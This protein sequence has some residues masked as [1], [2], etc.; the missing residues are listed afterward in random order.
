[1]AGA[2]TRTSGFPVGLRFSQVDDWAKAAFAGDVLQ[3]SADLKSAAE[4]AHRFLAQLPPSNRNV[5][6]A[7]SLVD[8]IQHISGELHKDAGRLL[9]MLP[10][11]NPESKARVVVKRARDEWQVRVYDDEGKL[12]EA[13]TYHTNDKDDAYSTKAAIEKRLGIAPTPPKPKPKIRYRATNKLGSLLDTLYAAIDKAVNTFVSSTAEIP[14]PP[15]PREWAQDVVDTFDEVL[16][17]LE[18]IDE[19]GGGN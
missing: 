4:R 9:G 16:R 3:L 15:G 17:E 1:M 18:R 2:K 5:K 7:R 8:A 19:Q 11:P 12:N 13:A 6:R 14:L 10:K